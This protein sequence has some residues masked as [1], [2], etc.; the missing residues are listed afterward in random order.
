M[1][2]EMR[3]QINK[4]KNYKQFLTENRNSQIGE[5]RDYLKSNCR[6]WEYDSDNYDDT[7]SLTNHLQQ[8]FSDLSFDEIFNIAKDWTGYEE[9]VE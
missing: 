3:E 6:S 4:V 2:K 9:S 5:L 7:V 8:R 1:S